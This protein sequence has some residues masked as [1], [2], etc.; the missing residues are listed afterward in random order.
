MNTKVCAHCEKPES[1]WTDPRQ[2]L[3]T[4]LGGFD[5]CSEECDSSW[6]KHRIGA[7]RR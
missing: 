1:E 4:I 5:F 6:M 7:K 3:D 2:L